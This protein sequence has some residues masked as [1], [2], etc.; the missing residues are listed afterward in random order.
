MSSTTSDPRSLLIVYVASTVAAVFLNCLNIDPLNVTVFNAAKPRDALTIASLAI[1]WILRFS[2]LAGVWSTFAL[3]VEFR[4]DLLGVDDESAFMYESKER[5][6]VTVARFAAFAAT[7]TLGFLAKFAS[8]FLMRYADFSGKVLA[9]D[10]NM[11]G[12]QAR[13]ASSA[14]QRAA[15]TESQ[16]SD[17]KS[18]SDK[19]AFDAVK[20]APYKAFNI[21]IKQARKLYK[22]V[23]KFNLKLTSTPLD[24][25]TY[26]TYSHLVQFGFLFSICAPL[27]I[28]ICN[29]H[30]LFRESGD[31]RADD[32]Y[33]DEAYRN[34]LTIFI[35]IALAVLTLVGLIE[36]GE[37]H[38]KRKADDDV[39][40]YCCNMFMIYYTDTPDDEKRLDAERGDGIV[41]DSIF[42]MGPGS[43][44]GYPMNTAILSCVW[45]ADFICMMPYYHN[46]TQLIVFTWITLVIPV[47]L[48]G[49]HGKAAVFLDIWVI[50][51]VMHSLIVT[52]LP[53]WGYRLDRYH[54]VNNPGGFNLAAGMDCP[55]KFHT[56]CFLNLIDY[57]TQYTGEPLAESMRWWCGILGA[58]TVMTMFTLLVVFVTKKLYV[59][60]KAS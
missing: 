47:I 57:P 20:N 23:E 2:F 53:A 42:G 26:V 37:L 29:L 59:K 30:Q 13:I 35:S 25:D 15:S 9:V 48:T 60:A 11:N 44:S 27:I 31:V 55:E 45:L 34:V 3:F 41:H 18:L 43:L 46:H 38:M 32:I 14:L 51:N 52:F 33:P 54:A 28:G 21:P 19:S 6:N 16:G 4:N 40:K 49:L 39:D 7:F 1:T 10:S 17:E 36:L 12:V 22:A 56:G 8:D 5:A 58:L 50:A 24:E